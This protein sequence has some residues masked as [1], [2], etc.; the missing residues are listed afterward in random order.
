M[1]VRKMSKDN[2]KMSKE[3]I[4]YIISDGKF[5]NLSDGQKSV[6]KESLP[7][8][9]FDMTKDNVIKNSVFVDKW[10]DT[11]KISYN[12]KSKWMAY[13][14]SQQQA[15]QL[16]KRFDKEFDKTISP[17]ENLRILINDI[18]LEEF[19]KKSLSKIADDK[20]WFIFNKDISKVLKLEYNMF[21]FDFIDLKSDF[22]TRDDVKTWIVYWGEKALFQIQHPPSKE[23]RRKN[24]VILRINTEHLEE[25]IKEV[26]ITNETWGISV[27]VALCRINGIK[28][29]IEYKG[30]FDEKMV[31]EVSIAL[32]E[33]M[34]KKIIPTMTECLAT[35]TIGAKKSP[36]DFMNNSETI[37]VKTNFNG[38]NKVCPPEFGQ[39]GIDEGVRQYNNHFKN[40]VTREEIINL[41]FKNFKKQFQENIASIANEQLKQLFSED[42][43][44]YLRKTKGGKISIEYI[45]SSDKDFEF[46]DEFTFT[47]TYVEWNDSVSIKYKGASLA[48]MQMHKGRSPFKFRFNLPNLMKIIKNDKS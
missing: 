10:N 16:L 7:K 11:Y 30:R 34:V 18:G 42:S 25:F 12:K 41:N 35:K 17:L 38:G 13:N 3:I 45:D 46:K 2:S 20:I 8:I 28:M 4:N 24:A 37:S 14:K 23:V 15:P 43:I 29:P 26:K 1:K 19:F 6:I 27:E 44:L 47:R 36:T 32:N 33:A 21:D 31:S 5:P 22:L 9:M 40:N 48:E 39:P